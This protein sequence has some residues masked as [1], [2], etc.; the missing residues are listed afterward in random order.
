ML[1]Q[2]IIPKFY[3]MNNRFIN[4]ENFKN[5]CKEIE[6]FPIIFAFFG[7]VWFFYFIAMVYRVVNYIINNK[8]KT[9]SRKIKKIQDLDY[10]IQSQARDL[11]TKYQK[12]NEDIRELFGKFRN[13]VIKGDDRLLVSINLLEFEMEL[14]LRTFNNFCITKN[15]DL[16]EFD[17]FY[18][19]DLF[20]YYETIVKYNSVVN[21]CNGILNIKEIIN[22]FDY[23][24]K[25]LEDALLN[26][27][28]V[29]KKNEAEALSIFKN[30]LLNQYLPIYLEI[31]YKLQS[32]GI[33][34]LRETE[35]IVQAKME[36]ENSQFEIKTCNVKLE[37]L[38]YN[39]LEA[40]KL[41]EIQE[42]ILDFRVKTFKLGKKLMPENIDNNNTLENFK[43]TFNEKD[44][45]ADDCFKNIDVPLARM[46]YYI[47][48]KIYRGRWIAAKDSCIVKIALNKRLNN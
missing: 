5:L 27:L 38:S 36:K 1:L 4:D 25:Q 40:M 3:E 21:D 12:I 10:A 30:D 44:E 43:C 32:F 48:R 23:K 11:V 26:H 13:Y 20:S 18:F 24:S 6:W 16:E 9:I 46:R 35:L 41:I 37:K 34:Q 14:F 31:E 17:N 2:E 45:F 42:N 29:T 47:M 33:F 7:C 8:T 15:Y 39:N 22:K 28:N 19:P